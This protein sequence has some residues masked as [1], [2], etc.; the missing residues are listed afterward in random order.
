MPTTSTAAYGL[1]AYVRHRPE[2]T[3]LYEIVQDHLDPFLAH[4]REQGGRP[5]PRYVE[6]EFREY[7]RCGILAHGFLRLYCDRCGKDLLVA[8]SCKGR[9]L[10]P[11]CGARR[12]SGNAAQLAD[13]VFPDVPLRQWVLSVPFDLRLLLASK[14]EVL[15]AVIRIFI[16]EVF[17]WYTGQ[18]KSYGLAEPKCGAVTFTQRFGGSLNL[19]VHL[20][21]ITRCA[22]FRQQGWRQ[23]AA[24]LDRADG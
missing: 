1:G 16:E 18:A 2:D 10:C 11:S 24:A 21:V 15:S 22:K 12:M 23:I 5:L 17:R 3:L 6:R 14:A 9:G 4:V 7:L 20:H 13:R 19:N 8:F